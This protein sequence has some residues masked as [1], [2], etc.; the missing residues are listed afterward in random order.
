MVMRYCLLI[1]T[2]LFLNICYAMENEKFVPIEQEN[3]PKLVGKF[4]VVKTNDAVYEHG[5]LGDKILNTAYYQVYVNN[6][7]TKR[8][9]YQAEQLYYDKGEDYTIMNRE[10]NKRRLKNKKR[11]YSLD[12]FRD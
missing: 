3:L 7:W 11:S 12:F 5:I 6:D 1:F 8:N 9:L 2:C 4:I 10:E